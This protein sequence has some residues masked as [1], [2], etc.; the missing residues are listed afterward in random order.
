MEKAQIVQHNNMY[1]DCRQ[2][3]IALSHS[4]GYYHIVVLYARL[5]GQGGCRL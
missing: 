3:L 5:I 2:L 1:L 4:N